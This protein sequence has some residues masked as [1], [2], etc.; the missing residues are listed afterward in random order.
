[1]GARR[2]M[3]VRARPSTPSR[4]MTPR[5][6]AL[7]LAI[8]PEAARSARAFSGPR[9]GRAPRRRRCTRSAPGRFIGGARRVR[10]RERVE[11]CSS[12][13]TAAWGSLPIASVLSAFPADRRSG[14]TSSASRRPL[15]LGSITSWTDCRGTRAWIS[16][17]MVSAWRKQHVARYDG[18]GREA[19][20]ARL[21]VPSSRSSLIAGRTRPTEKG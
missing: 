2:T 18:R 10:D 3:S 14:R 19:T 5:A 1:V 11:W 16:N 15:R 12:I 6:R 13:D 7:H 17:K 9:G 21:F 20:R 8:A 4:P